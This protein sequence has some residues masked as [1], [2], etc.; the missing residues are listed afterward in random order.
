MNASELERYRRHLSLPEVGL[1]GQYRLKQSKVLCIGAGGL[2]TAALQYLVAAGV[3]HIGIVDFDRVECSNLQ[4]Q[5]L[6]TTADIGQLKAIVASERLKALNPSIEITAY[7]FALNDENALALLSDYDVILDASDNFATRYLINDACFELRKPDVFASVLRFKGLCTVFAA[8]EGPCYRCLFPV[9]PAPE[10]VQNCAEAGVIGAFTGLLGSMQA[11]EAIKLLLQIG[12]SLTGRLLT[13]D[14]LSCHWQELKLAQNPDCPLCAKN[15]PFAALTRPKAQCQKTI[16]E[17][18]PQELQRLKD[19]N[20]G[21]FLL[22]VRTEAEYNEGHL[23]GYLIPLDELPYR[24][25]ELNQQ[26][27]IVVYCRVGERSKLAIQILSHYGFTNLHN[28]KGGILAW[29]AES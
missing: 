24:L 5:I 9:A 13:L 6:Y 18:S 29:Q 17:I 20:V 3:G 16:S 19:D 23:N 10:L 2:G 15:I 14:A 28:L 11:L 21:F 27:M 1:S 26:D 22:D 12:D 7:P 4:R 25:N 8:A